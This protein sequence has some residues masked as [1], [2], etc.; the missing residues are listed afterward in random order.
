MTES[1]VKS[2]ERVLD[3]FEALS[4]TSSGMT[5]SALQ[6]ALGVPKSSLHA[7]LDVLT[8]RSYLHLDP[9]T[10]SYTIGIRFWERSQAYQRHH[11]LVHEALP[12][13]QQIVQAI[14]ETVQLAILDSSENVYLAKVD[15]SHPLRLQSEVGRRLPAYATGLGKVLLSNLAETDLETR[16]QEPLQ[17][18]TP[19]TLAERNALYT[20]L[21]RVRE[22]GFAVDNQEYTLGVGCVAVP[23]GGYP[24]YCVAAMSV[25]VPISRATLDLFTEA[26]VQLAAGSLQIARRLGILEPDP[27]LL[28]ISARVAARNA[29]LEITANGRL[30]LGMVD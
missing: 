18:F 6:Q 2:A 9:T 19:H 26:L 28:E 12:V 22:R 7:L 3:I 11:S 10:R 1:T 17:R 13:M 30:R 21:G 23:I 16:L 24:N 27:R 8:K 4:E 15:S 14:N 25:S 20:E 29:L 5:F